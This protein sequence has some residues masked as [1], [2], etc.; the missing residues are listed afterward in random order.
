MF[1]PLPS[2]GL[3]DLLQD[4]ASK[5]GKVLWFSAPPLL[6]GEGKDCRKQWQT[7]FG[8]DY[9][10]TEYMGEMAPGKVVDFNLK[11]VMPQVILTDF[12]VDRIYP[13]S[14]APSA[15]TV[16]TVE[17]MVVG[18]CNKVGKGEAWYF[19]FRPRDDQSAS[20]GY[21]T[22]T[23]F[24]ILCA[25][26]AYPS[27][28]RFAVNDN[29]VVVSRTTDVF[30]AKF[31]SGAT[32]IVKHYRNHRESWEGGFSRDAARDAKALEANPLPSDA[33]DL[34]GLKVN[35][36]EVTYSGK[37]NMAFNT[38]VDGRLNAFNGREAQSIT[39]DGVVYNLSDRP[40][41]IA[42]GPVEGSAGKIRVYADRPCRLCIPLP[43]GTKKVS[44]K[45][46]KTAVE[47]TLEGG[48]L[49][50]DAVSGGWFDVT[51]K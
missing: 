9:H 35:G 2:K 38:G 41:N 34:K 33:L 21:E 15:S 25:V 26:G 32:A 19:G 10:H 17:D 47:G 46:G 48:N 45:Q 40:A 11:D 51:V 30:A 5:G 43:S 4:F 50:F 39:L 14:P 37:R 27:T 29:P 23:L 3:L 16:A 7:I 36:H 22:R 1:E 8:A 49:V 31:P 24:E 20:L 28:G 13:V 12:L 42:F 44:V 6:D 18:T